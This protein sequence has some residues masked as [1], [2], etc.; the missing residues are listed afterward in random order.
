MHTFLRQLLMLLRFMT[1]INTYSSNISRHLQWDAD[2][3]ATP[4]GALSNTKTRSPGFFSLFIPFCRHDSIIFEGKQAVKGVRWTFFSCHIIVSFEP[5]DVE[6]VTSALPLVASLCEQSISQSPLSLHF[7]EFSLWV[8]WVNLPPSCHWFC[9]NKFQNH[10][11]NAYPKPTV[12]FYYN[13]I[14]STSK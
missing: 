13:G 12:M 5:D 14:Y 8:L 2:T 7:T 10:F 9:E 6:F 4:T 1:E 11:E 3:S